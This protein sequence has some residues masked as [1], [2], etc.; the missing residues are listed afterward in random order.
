MIVLK[1][2]SVTLRA[3]VSGGRIPVAALD[4]TFLICFY[5]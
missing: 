4:L 5:P 1:A 2:I 3:Q